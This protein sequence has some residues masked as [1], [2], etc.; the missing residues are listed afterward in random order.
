M[1]YTKIQ[2]KNSRF[3]AIANFGISK[4]SVR[5][6]LRNSDSDVRNPEIGRYGSVFRNSDSERFY[7]IP[8]TPACNTIPNFMSYVY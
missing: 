8:Q 5:V 1:P 2:T 3:N 7:G 4:N 6:E